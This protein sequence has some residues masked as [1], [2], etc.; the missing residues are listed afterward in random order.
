[1][2]LARR[3]SLPAACFLALGLSLPLQ[4]ATA[5]YTDVWWAVG[6]SETGWGVNFAQNGDFVFATFFV[7]GP[8]FQPTWYSAEMTTINGGVTYTGPLYHTTGSWFG[9][10]WK[11]AEHPPATLVGNATFTPSTATTGML[12]YSVNNLPE[13]QAIVTKAIQRFTLKS[14]NIA[15][16]YV[17]TGVVSVTGCSDSSQNGTSLFDVDPEITQGV[18]GQ[19]GVTLSFNNEKCMLTGAAIQEGQ[20]LQMPGASYVCATGNTTTLNTTANV[21]EVRATAIGIEGRWSA[22][23]SGG[24]NENG[25]FSA[26]LR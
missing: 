14:I 20:L 21:H 8:S 9:A 18:S 13:G 22:N 11:P 16:S 1:M 26:V 15:G 7:Y 6:G 4:A 2:H 24:C 23:T 25:R 5:D 12:T 19:V 17:G 10:A 3:H